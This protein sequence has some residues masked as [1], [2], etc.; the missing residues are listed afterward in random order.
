MP[1]ANGTSGG[2][3]DTFDRR[4]RIP[5]IA[6]YCESDVVKTCRVWLGYALCRWRGNLQPVQSMARG[7]SATPSSS[8]LWLDF[9]MEL[10]K[11]A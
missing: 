3:A 1:G 10:A 5:E 6:E 4:L 7:V 8:A 11:R 9:N 2:D